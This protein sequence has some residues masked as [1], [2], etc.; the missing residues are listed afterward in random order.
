MHD[1][2]VVLFESVH[3]IWCSDSIHHKNLIR[4]WKQNGRE[5]ER[6]CQ[7]KKEIN[8]KLDE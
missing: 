4:R 5:S 7:K 6:N 8:I 3:F 2:D 1:I